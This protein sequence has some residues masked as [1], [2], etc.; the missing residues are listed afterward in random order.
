MSM[1]SELKELGVDVEDA[2][3]RFMGNEALFTR[4]VKKLPPVARDL[5]VIEYLDG[6]DYETA[7]NNAHTLKGVMGNLSVTPLFQ[8]YNDAVNALRAN[9]PE[10]ARKSVEGIVTLQEQI[11]ACIEKYQ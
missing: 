11:A 4:M 6:G 1:I 7:L 3:Q 10:E 2:L 5:K 8:A 9:K